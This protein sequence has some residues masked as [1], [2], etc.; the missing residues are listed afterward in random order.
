MNFVQHL[1]YYILLAFLFLLS[2]LPLRLLY[3]LAEFFNVIIFRLFRYRK[4][5]VL[6]NLRNAFPE[7][8][9]T[10]IQTICRKF[11]RHFACLVVENLE[12]RFVNLSRFKKRYVFENEEL[13]YD[14]YSKGK[15]VVNIAA[16]IGNW[17]YAS[18]AAGNLPFKTVA[19]YK[20]LSNKTFDK[21]FIKIRTRLKNEPIEMNDVLRKVVQLAK[22]KEQFLLSMV[23]DQAPMLSSSKHWITFLNQDTN[24]FLGPERIAKKFNTAVIY[25]EIIRHKKGVYKITPKLIT[26]NAAEMNEFEIT[27]TYFKL[28]EQSIQKHPRYWLWTH[29]R[30][31]HKKPVN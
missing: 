23:A 24:V 3:L 29:R 21:L 7:K 12:I 30:W 18:G 14:L 19:V 4:K 15:N 2:L 10:D 22:G 13:F 5:V 26:E 28:L 1:S 9:E 8:S 31:K 20:Q 17:E 16:H 11:Y 6:E 27:E 25:T